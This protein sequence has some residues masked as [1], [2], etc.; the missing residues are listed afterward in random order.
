M[1]APV[2]HLTQR[3]RPPPGEF[4]RLHQVEHALVRPGLVTLGA[5]ATDEQRVAACVEAVFAAHHLERLFQGR[6]LEFDHLAAGAALEVFVLR[7]AVIV[8]VALARP[9]FQLAQQSGIDQFLEGAVDGG[10]AGLIA[11]LLQRVDE[12]IG[13][14]VVVLLEDV[15]DQIALLFGVALRPG[16]AGQVFA[17]LLFGTLG[18]AH[19]WKGHLTP[20]GDERTA[21]PGWPTLAG[22]LSRMILEYQYTRATSP[23]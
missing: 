19:R 16:A 3:T 21:S 17:E 12:L 22:W 13:V 20:P 15:V 14:E 8:L 5:G 11:A 7:V 9:Q 2:R 1:A 4:A 10:A 6:T 23:G 18:N